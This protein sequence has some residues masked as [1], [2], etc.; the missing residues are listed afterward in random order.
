MT[1]RPAPVAGVSSEDRSVSAQS[2][3][4]RPLRYL[5]LTFLATFTLWFAGAYVSFQEGRE[6]LYLLFMLSGLM[7]PFFT[8]LLMMFT[9]S[10]AGVKRDFFNRLL[11]P[12]LIRL[13][14]LPVMLLLMPLVVMVSIVLSLPFGGSLA[15]FQLSE[16][17]SFSYGAVPSLLLLMLAA[18]FEEL[19]WRGYAFDSL[20]QRYSYLTAAI[21]FGVVWSLWH[22]P[23]IFVH[24]SYQYEIMHQNVWYGIN[25]FVGTV[26]LGI[27]VS[28]ICSKNHKSI[29]AAIAFHFII[30]ISQ[31]ALAITQTTKCIETVVLAAVAVGL[32][33]LDRE[34]FFSKKSSL[35]PNH[36]Q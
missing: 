16:G 31:E 19:G 14:M 33:V 8:A 24:N 13:S 7:A 30:N 10:H 27:I 6:G 2:F 29:F 28:W 15:Q 11:N 34:L 18:I 9:S 3:Q 35:A 5:A 1:L 20:E 17:F 4:Y 36:G 21:L 32:I 26:I 25:F 12:R 23:L 22:A